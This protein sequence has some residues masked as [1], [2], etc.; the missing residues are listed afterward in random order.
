[1]AF[2]RIVRDRAF[3]KSVIFLGLLFAI[4]YQ[5]ISMLFDYGGLEFSSF[6]EDKLAGSRWIRF[7]IGTLAAAFVYGFIISYGQFR[8]KIKK[9]RRENNVEK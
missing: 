5:F 4:I 1:M 7:T 9:E 2:K 8:S 3:W 6:Y